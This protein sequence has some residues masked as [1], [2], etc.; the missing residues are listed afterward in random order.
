MES[1]AGTQTGGKVDETPNAPEPV[2]ST[3]LVPFLTHSAQELDNVP[4]ELNA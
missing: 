3:L 1:D 4:S 2:D